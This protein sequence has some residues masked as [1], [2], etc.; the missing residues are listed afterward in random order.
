MSSSVLHQSTDRPASQNCPKLPKVPDSADDNSLN[1]QQLRAIDALLRGLTFTD[2]AQ[3]AG[4][5]RRTLYA[6]RREDQ[7][8]R[9]ELQRRREVL[10][11]A[12]AD[13]IR[14]LIPS[15]I[16]ILAEQLHE[17]FDQNRVRAAGML[18]RLAN[19]R[20]AVPV[21]PREL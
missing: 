3:A 12:G 15:A 8:F 4:V 2:V 13:Q 20:G 17:P 10:W 9:D 21:T 11:E 16:A 6:W 7:A 5:S 18:L 14:S 1:D 19:I